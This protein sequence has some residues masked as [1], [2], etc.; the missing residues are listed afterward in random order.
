MLGDRAPGGLAEPIALGRVADQAGRS[1]ARAR[2]RRPAGTSSI[3]SPAAA[4]SSAPVPAPPIVGSPAA[5]A[6]TWATPKASWMLGI[7]WTWPRAMLSSA[8]LVRH[9]ARETRPVGD[10]ELARELLER[11]AVRALADQHVAQ[12]RDGAA[13]AR[14]ARGSRPPGSCAARGARPSPASDPGRVG[15]CA[16]AG[17][18][19]GGSRRSA[20][21][22]AGQLLDPRA[23]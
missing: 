14:R 6:S 11:V 16:R 5:I 21:S 4:M 20:G 1:P 3:P 15:D 10:A 7:T 18:R 8:V 17:R 12:R 13:S 2:R 22:G 19:R 23:A 9:R